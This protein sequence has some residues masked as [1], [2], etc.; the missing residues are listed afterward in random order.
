MLETSHTMAKYK[1]KRT[2]NQR[3][4]CKMCKP[5]KINGNNH[6]FGFDPKPPADMR[7][8]QE[9]LDDIVQE[10]HYY[11]YDYDWWDDQGL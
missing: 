6:N 9:P 5:W 8:L 3:A 2:A 4:G 1:K 7:E 11:D 10:Y